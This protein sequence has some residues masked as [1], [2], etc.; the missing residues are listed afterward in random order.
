MNI[1]CTDDT[2]QLKKGKGGATLKKATK[3]YI[4]GVWNDDSTTGTTNQSGDL[5]LDKYI[6]ALINKGF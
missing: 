3:C 2:I 1:Q 4:I 6:K 5:A